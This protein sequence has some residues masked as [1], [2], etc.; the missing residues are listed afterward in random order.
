ML[1]LDGLQKLLHGPDCIV[2]AGKEAFIPMGVDYSG[3]RSKSRISSNM[4]S[5]LDIRSRMQHKRERLAKTS[6]LYM[7][8]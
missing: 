4:G 6:R 7:R 1:Q 5:R 8:S 3:T 2:A